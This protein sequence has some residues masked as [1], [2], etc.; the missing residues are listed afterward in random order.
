[1]MIGV[2]PEAFDQRKPVA[3]QPRPETIRDLIR[4]LAADTSNISWGAHALERMDERGIT[5]RVAIEALRYG[6]LRGNIEAGN[7]PGEWKAKMVRQVKGRREVGVIVV[8][9]RNARLFVKTVEWE[10]IR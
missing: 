8:T 2:M 10:D 9:V 1:M 6:D 3:F 7:S 5:D 4:R